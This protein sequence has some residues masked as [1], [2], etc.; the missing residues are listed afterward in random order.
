MFT[1]YL[2][3]ELANNINKNNLFLKVKFASIVENVFLNKDNTFFFK[4]I[5]TKEKNNE[6]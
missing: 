3:K 4:Y 5:N 1:N 6:N 2:D